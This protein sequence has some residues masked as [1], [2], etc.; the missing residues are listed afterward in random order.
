MSIWTIILII[1]RGR[2]RGKW[3]K[4][5]M[6]RS[7]MKVIMI[8]LITVQTMDH[9]YYFELILYPPYTLFYYFAVFS[10][11]IMQMSSLLCTQ[12]LFLCHCYFRNW[13]GMY[14]IKHGNAKQCELCLFQCR[15]NKCLVSRSKRYLPLFSCLCL[16]SYKDI[17]FPLVNPTISQWWVLSGKCTLYRPI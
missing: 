15:V 11:I 13:I 10:I 7:W 2:G 12:G 1:R 4:K 8:N 14:H 5:Q 9:D 17:S 6:R 16:V 3:R